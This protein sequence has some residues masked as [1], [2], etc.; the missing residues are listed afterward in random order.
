MQQMMRQ[1]RNYDD[2]W[3]K[4]KECANGCGWVAAPPHCAYAQEK[5]RRYPCS[6]HAVALACAM[7]K[8]KAGAGWHDS[9]GKFYCQSCLRAGDLA[10][11]L[12]PV[13]DVDACMQRTH[14]G[15]T[16]LERSTSMLCRSCLEWCRETRTWYMQ[17]LP[18]LQQVVEAMENNQRYAH[19]MEQVAMTA[20]A[21]HRNG[22]YPG[23]PPPQLAAPA[24]VHD[25]W[26]PQPQQQQHGPVQMPLGVPLRVP[27]PPPGPMPPN[28][29]IDPA[30]LAANQGVAAARQGAAAVAAAH[31]AQPID[32]PHVPMTEADGASQPGAPGNE[33]QHYWELRLSMEKLVNTLIAKKVLTC[34]EGVEIMPG[35]ES[36][37]SSD[38]GGNAVGAP[39]ALTDQ[40]GG[41]RAGAPAASSASDG[42]WLREDGTRES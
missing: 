8:K 1:M 12:D 21:N 4:R 23:L 28:L 9:E 42:S 6:A 20:A 22:G 13:Y 36:S 24:N 19:E 35:F 34:A 10:A 11:E 15:R 27:G 40:A 5:G 17:N 29:P 30:A 2:A 38:S 41:E 25:P 7:N 33:G 32:V 31:P 16:E 18:P 14:K 39:P 26:Q 37:S 3:D